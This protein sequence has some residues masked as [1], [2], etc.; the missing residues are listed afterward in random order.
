V[1]GL[2]RHHHEAIEQLRQGVSATEPVSQYYAHLFLEREF[3]MLGNGPEAR[4]SYERATKL[5]PMA[6]SPLFGL[7]RLAEHRGNRVAARDAV[8]HMLALPPIE[9]DRSDPWWVYE[10][11]QARAVDAMLPTCDNV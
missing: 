9:F 3:E 7:S 2:R 11:V 1:L 6:Q 4:Q 8:A 10:V 5:A